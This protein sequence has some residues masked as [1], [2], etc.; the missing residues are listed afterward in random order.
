MHVGFLFNHYVGHQVYH[1]APVAFALSTKYPQVQVSIIVADPKQ[2]AIVRSIAN[3]WP[4][5]NCQ[6][7]QAH[8]PFYAKV[9]DK[10]IGKFVLVRKWAVLRAN[11]HLFKQ[12]DVMVV[13][14][15]TSL[16]LKKDPDLAHLKM[17]RIR[18]GAGDRQTSFGT[19][20]NQF[21]LLLASG[22]KIRERLMKDSG[23]PEEKIMIVGYP[24]FDVLTH[25]RPD[26]IFDNENP[27][28]VYNPHYKRGESSF[29]DWGREI[30]EFF[31]DNPQ[32]NLIF[33]PHVLLY[34]RKW[35]HG[36]FDVSE[37]ADYPNIYIDTG[38]SKSLDMTY[39]RQADVY[40]GDV[41]SQIYEFIETPR[42]CIFLN[43]HGFQWQGNKI[44]KY[45]EGG[46]V[47]ENI[48]QL[49][50][51]MQNIFDDHE[52]TYKKRQEELFNATFSLTGIPS[53]ERSAD[54]IVQAFA[55]EEIKDKRRR[56]A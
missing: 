27:V 52:R 19:D 42:P 29:Q 15:K 5:H 10:I 37:Y 36:A 20:Q 3:D 49:P 55:P 7:I 51:T 45:W 43:P 32:Y 31:K 11:K 14:E 46:A 48:K 2:L 30:L 18:H 56:G 38:S 26:A 23:V 34:L 12:I 41:S 47:V 25:H 9:L 8:V 16:T 1:S 24:K 44:F 40:L 33:A 50:A 13:P 22:N 28:V 21:D 35:R 4:N 39:L 54:A 17:V 53:C 6:I